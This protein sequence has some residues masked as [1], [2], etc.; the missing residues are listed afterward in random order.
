[1]TYDIEY[2]TG[3]TDDVGAVL[4]MDGEAIDLTGMTVSFVMKSAAGT[5][6]TLACSLGGTVNNIYVPETAG[7]CT[8]HFDETATG[9]AGIYRGE[10]IVSLGDADVHIPSG[11]NFVN[12]VIWESL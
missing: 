6:E 12:I 3:D 11:N 4:S 7:G 10:F 1:M 9:T 8:I 5:K 2:K